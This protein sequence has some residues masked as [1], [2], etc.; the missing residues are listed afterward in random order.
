MLTYLL[1][2]L[3]ALACDSSSNG[4]T[5]PGTTGPD[6]YA[7]A[8]VAAVNQINAYRATKR[9]PPLAHCADADSCADQ[10]AKHDSEVGQAHASFGSCG[11]Q[12]QNECPGWP[13]SDAIVSGCL[14]MM[15]NEGPGSDYSKH[16]HYINMTNPAYTKV[17]IGFYTTP[18]GEVWS[19][20]NFK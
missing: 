11:E 1:L 7:T 4:P 6:L 9:L 20:Q 19:V 17:S 18:G 3:L 5:R 10:E 15:W 13:S 14:E 16:G 2:P 12:A 8:R